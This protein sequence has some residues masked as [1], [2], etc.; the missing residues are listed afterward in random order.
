M[1]NYLQIILC[2]VILFFLQKNCYSKNIKIRLSNELSLEETSFENLYGWNNENYK[3]ALDVFLDN[4][5]R[6]VSLSIKYYG[7]GYIVCTTAFVSET[8]Y[9]SYILTDSRKLLFF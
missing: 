5:E 2:C 9:L 8:S 7:S 4:C 6:I 1:I 3:E